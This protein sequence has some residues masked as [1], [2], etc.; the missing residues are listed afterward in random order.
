MQ[1]LTTKEIEELCYE[2]RQNLKDPLEFDT[3]QEIMDLV[4]AIK[5]NYEFKLTLSKD[6]IECMVG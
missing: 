5:Q 1:Q 6:T 2:V 4:K 3:I